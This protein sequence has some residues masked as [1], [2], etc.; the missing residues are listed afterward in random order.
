MRY[1][2]LA[3]LLVACAEGRGFEGTFNGYRTLKNGTKVVLVGGM[4]CP[5]DA[6]ELTPSLE[7]G[8]SVHFH[9][10]RCETTI[11]EFDK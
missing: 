2:L 7:V 9:I 1:V 8:D 5:L 4:F 11:A 3:L 10:E 6:V